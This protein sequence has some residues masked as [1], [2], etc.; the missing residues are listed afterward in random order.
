VTAL[1]PGLGGEAWYGALAALNLLALLLFVPVLLAW[2]RHGERRVAV[3]RTAAAIGAVSLVYG[4]LVRRGSIP[5]DWITVLHEG[6]D[7]QS[8]LHLYG[9]GVHAGMNFGFVSSLVAATPSATLHAVVWLNAWLALVNALWFGCLA[10]AI[11]G[12]RWGLIW[13][14]VFALNPATFLASF[15]ELPTNLLALYFLAGVSGWLALT[16]PLPQARGTRAA[17]WLL[18]AVLTVLSALTRVEVGMVGG[19]ALLV[20]GAHA[21]LGEPR[22]QA[23]RARAAAALWRG[24]AY[25][26]ARPVLVAALSALGWWLAMAGFP[27]L[28]GRSESAGL[29]PFNASILLFFAY[30]PTLLLP[31]GASLAIAGGFVYA[32]RDFRRLGGLALS[33]LVIVRTYF[34]AQDQ[35]YEMGRYLS[36][37]LPAVFLLGVY[38]T[39]QVA[40][41]C[42]DWPAPWS[43]A[44]R[45]VFIVS[46]FTHA[47]PGMPE[48]YLR[49]EYTRSGGVAQL[50]LDR[51]MQREVRALL[52]AVDD[53]PDCVFVARVLGKSAHP[54]SV[55][56]VFM[57]RDLPPQ[58]AYGLFGGPIAKPSFVAATAGVSIDAVLAQFAPQAT[59]V[60]LYFGGDCNLTYG[61]G[62]ADFIAGRTP[63]TS[64]RFWSRPYNNMFDYGYADS[65]VT[66]ATYAYR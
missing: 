24:L 30:L 58:Y 13:T 1:S 53:N 65:Q 33:L 46:W 37:V 10:I 4:L 64:E 8:I 20:H 25:L 59:C 28:L 15:S 19:T 56:D 47:L 23:L 36:Y 26:A 34:A 60:R 50:F 42:R 51:N 22:W 45:V 55:A 61:D 39:V 5:V 6:L 41:W 21:A 31:L 52:R 44:A 16:D 11:A 3:R 62:C 2:A 35:Y 38:G 9:R 49:P 40:A 32:T 12:R 17:G 29:Y 57:Q 48:F 66:L 18:C 7:L 27:I 14:A 43:H 63:L 54:P